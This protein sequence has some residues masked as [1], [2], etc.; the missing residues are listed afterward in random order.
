M[1]AQYTILIADDRPEGRVLLERL[2]TAEGYN[3]AFAG[4][5]IETLAKAAQLT[6]DLILLDVMMPNM[7]GFEVCQRLRADPLLAEVPVL[8]V[9]S[10]DDRVSRLHGLEM[11]ADDFITKPFD[12]TEL[13]ARVRTITQ[14]NRYRRLLLERA[15][16]QWVVENTDDGYLVINNNDDVL[17]AN[18]QA[19]HYLGLSPDQAELVAEPFL[20]LADKRYYRKPETGWETWPQ[21]PAETTP[22][23][24]MQPE[25]VSTYAF[26]LQVDLFPAEPGRSWIVRLRDVTKQ[27]NLQRDMRGFHEMVSH[28]LLTPILGMQVGLETMTRHASKLSVEE[29]GDLAAS[30]LKSLQRLEG[31]IQDIL[32]YLKVGTLAR[33]ETGF[34]LAQLANVVTEI[35]T[36]LELITVAVSGVEKLPGRRLTLSRQAMELVLREVLENAKKFHPRQSPT[37]NITVE[38]LNAKKV[39]LTA[40]DDGLTLSPEQL[41]QAW[42]PYYQGEKDFTGEV[43]GMGLGLSMVASLVWGAGGTVR[44][45]N[46]EDRPGVVVELILLVAEDNEPAI[47]H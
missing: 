6:P 19:R 8:M 45:Y 31:Q 28:K 21:L 35:G 25:T 42:M 39:C 2:L 34:E 24:L 33:A 16:F 17:Y 22:H 27:V 46:R 36:A 18:P 29:I 4:D 41:I 23:Y 7:N 38:P 32:Q 37:V 3:L 10:L 11:G 43:T 5:G 20:V 1:T 15:K 47:W 12:H 40:A 44:L 9:T 14:I 13:V 26:W 30:A